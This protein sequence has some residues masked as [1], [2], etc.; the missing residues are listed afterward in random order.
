MAGKNS[1]HAPAVDRALDVIELLASSENP[2]PLSEILT[3]LDIPKQS[4]IRILNTLCDR[5]VLDRTDQRGFYRHGMRFIY[6]GDRLQEKVRLRSVGR[7]LM[8]EL[9]EKTRM[10]VE[11]STL[12]RDQLV[13]IEQV[14]GSEGIR[15]YS[16]IGSAYPYFHAVAAG[17]IYL[18]NMAPEKRHKVLA[19]IGLPP[20]TKNTITEPR[21]LE[22]EIRRIKKK[23]YAVEDQE[24]RDGVR[25][26]VAP[27]HDHAHRLAGCVGIAATIFNFGIEQEEDLARQVT[28]TAERISA[29]IG[30]PR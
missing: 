18:A 15:L 30:R 16:R 27:I 19:A 10:T 9:A 12:D 13:L 17:K 28:E 2:M 25:R 3:R 11:L 6:L 20:M 5:G 23:G 22:E 4:L 21:V 29:G 7:P 1:N 8:R 14:E 24:L 26:I